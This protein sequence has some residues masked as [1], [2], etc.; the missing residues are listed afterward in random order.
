MTAAIALVACLGLPLS[1]GASID[2]AKDVSA[3]PTSTAVAIGRN[4]RDQLQPCAKRQG[5]PGQGAERIHVVVQL[6]LNRDG[7]L[8]APPRIVGHDGV[9]SVN[10]RYLG[11][12]ERAA[13][14]TVTECQ[15][16]RGF[17]PEWY[18]GPQGWA[19]MSIKYKL[20]G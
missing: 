13:I 12:V 9:D 3:M 4:I 6:E 17:P 1:A 8:A 19:R 5:S 11:Y 15:P 20:P 7:S 2:P 10:D 18:D 14:A 16:F